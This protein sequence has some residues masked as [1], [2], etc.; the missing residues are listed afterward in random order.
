[1][2]T[3]KYSG[4]EWIGDIPI[5]W[6]RSKIKNVCSMFG[7]GT[8]PDSHIM[9][10]YNGN[11]SWIQSGDIYGKSEIVSTSVNV[12][13]LALR[14][15]STLKVYSAPFVVIAMYGGSVGN[16]AI[17]S[18]DACS[19]Q[20]CCC[21]KP[22]NDVIIRFLYYWLDFC[23][24]DFLIKAEGGG[25]PNISQ[26]KIKN[27]AIY[28][29]N[30]IEQKAMIAYLDFICAEIDALFAD[31]QSEVDTLEAYKRSVIT[32][33]VTKGLD[34]NVPMK[35]SGIEW[36]GEI[37]A[38]WIMQRG[39]YAFEQKSTRGNSK[40]LVLLSPTQNYGVIPQ[41]M[42]EELSGFSAVKLNEKTDYNSLKTVHKGAFVISLRSFQG[43]F[44]YSEY[45]GVVSPAYQVFYPTIPV[46]DRY[47]KYLFKTQIFIDKM[48]SYT[49]SLR[50]GKNIAFADFGRTYIPIPPID[51]QTI[52]ANYL[53]NMCAQLNDVIAQ[54]QEQLAVLAEYKKSIIYEYITGKK[55]VPYGDF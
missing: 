27:Q 6:T 33:A 1:M 8:T 42:Y 54:K 5:G 52:I 55:E 32:E 21:M 28:F 4:I 36:V 46:C 2:R 49:M 11:V 7:S 26:N 13:T 48:N 24:Q 15:S 17:S 3:M 19:N 25:Q 9:D 12:T 29:P 53:D 41:D 45:E 20:A 39:K 14:S 31:I 34:K 30:I 51:E 16:I 23:K 38:H 43:G 37:P 40:S 22:N 47:Y 10:Y 44:E 18:I 50:D 35:D